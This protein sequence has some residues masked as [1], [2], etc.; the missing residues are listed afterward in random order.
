MHTPHR[1]AANTSRSRAMGKGRVFKRRMK[2]SLI[3]GYCHG[4]LPAA[5]V[6]WAFRALRLGSE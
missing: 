4:L 6:V 5:A 1:H 2:R 3:T